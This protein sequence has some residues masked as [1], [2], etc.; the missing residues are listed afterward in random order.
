MN[1]LCVTK[2]LFI[3]KNFA[4]RR[5]LCRCLLKFQK[6]KRFYNDKTF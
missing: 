4:A 1:E 2:L 5:P 3:Y 6:V